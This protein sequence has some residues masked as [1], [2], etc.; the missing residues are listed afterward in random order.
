MGIGRVATFRRNFGWLCEHFPVAMWE[1]DQRGRVR[2]C[3]S[4][5]GETVPSWKPLP[6]GASIGDWK[7]GEAVRTAVEQVHERALDRFGKVVPLAVPLE[8]AERSWLRGWCRAIGR[9]RRYLRG[10]VTLAWVRE[11]PPLTNAHFEL[12]AYST[13]SMGGRSWERRITPAQSIVRVVADCLVIVDGEGR[14][15]HVERVDANCPWHPEKG[16]KL[17]EGIKK[18]SA[19]VFLASLKRVAESGNPE[20]VE[21]C[22]R[23]REGRD[24]VRWYELRM[25][26]MEGSSDIV[27]TAHNVT[28]RKAR[29]IENREE[30]ERLRFLCE[31]MDRER[32]RMVHEIH[33]GFLQNLSAVRM[34]IE[35][36]LQDPDA[37]ALDPLDQALARLDE[38]IVDGRRLMSGLRPLILEETNLITALEYLKE[39]FA[40]LGA[41]PIHVRT[42]TRLNRLD[43]QFEGSVYRIIQE[44]VYNAIR[45]SGAS[46]I[47]IRLTHVPCVQDPFFV[48]EVWDNGR[49]FDV[50]TVPKDRF[51]IRGMRERA[52]AFGG[53]LSIESQPGTGTRITAKVPIRPA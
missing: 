25:S 19:V 1:I 9:G 14:V 41:P 36:V 39:E 27:V 44:A 43:P 26:R 48:I 22:T 46:E 49:G 31:I 51:G 53:D 37:R 21:V 11:A 4:G 6:E 2:W 8:S 28:Q 12:S 35:K 29:E 15:R 32:N 30:R 16:Q 45:H 5:I 20:V 33:D 18:E 10:T 23:P 47:T 3:T 7:V 34:C 42:R 40:Q 52:V 24:E 50:R 17:A 38:L 13:L